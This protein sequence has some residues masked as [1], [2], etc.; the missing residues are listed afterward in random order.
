MPISQLHA[1]SRVDTH[2]S[3]QADVWDEDRGRPRFK[4]AP[5]PRDVITAPDALL[6]DSA[7]IVAEMQSVFHE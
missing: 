7:S 5:K 2:Q 1:F 6:F 3:W 4:K